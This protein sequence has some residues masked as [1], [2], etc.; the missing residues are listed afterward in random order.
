VLNFHG[1][2]TPERALEPGEAP[3][4]ITLDRFEAILDLV[5]A[6]PDRDRIRL[7]F[8]DGNR[9][10][11]TLGSPQLK[12]RG[13]TATCFVL[14]G[15]I[16]AAGSLG[17]DDIAAL[18]QAGMAV[19]SHGVAHVDWR[20]LDAADLAAE[21]GGSRRR[22][23]EIF[24]RPVVAAASTFGGDN[25]RV[26]QGLAAAGYHEAYSSDGGPMAEGAFLRPR[27]TITADTTLTEVAAFL[28][29]EEPLARRLR[30]T[31]ATAI[32][33]WR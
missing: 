9:S 32:K 1:I 7:T 20:R 17:C 22:L 26:L 11:L 24:G 25:G 5:A 4:W 2:G 29:G 33:R 14:T 28:A 15:R 30:R 13:L 23:V 19:G 18:L 8:D 6:R 10:D 21:L 12:M 3:Y 16:G 31:V 27:Q